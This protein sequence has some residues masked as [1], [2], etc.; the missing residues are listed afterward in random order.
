MMHSPIKISERWT[1]KLL[2]NHGRLGLWEDQFTEST[3]YVKSKLREGRVTGNIFMENG[4]SAVN[5]IQA[6]ST[7]LIERS[8]LA[9][10]SYGKYK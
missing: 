8:I 2:K 3:N 6:I 1:H 10:P 4:K 9:K 5:E 7:L